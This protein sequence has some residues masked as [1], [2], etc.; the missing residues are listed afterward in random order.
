MLLLVFAASSSFAQYY[1][2]NDQYYDRDL[3]F[4]FGASI[5][6]MNSITDIGGAK[7]KGGLYV[8]EFNGK[9]TQMATGFYAGAL[10]RNLA[11]V[12]IEATWGSVRGADD[13]LKGASDEQVLN[14]YKR[15]LT[16]YSDIN[17]ISIVTEFHPLSIRETEAPVTLSP[18]IMLGI[19]RFAFNPQIQMNGRYVDL[20][21]LHTEGQGMKEYKGR[22]PYRLRQTNIPFG[23]GIKYDLNSLFTIRAEVLH[24]FL[25]TD[26]LDDVSTT[27]IDRSLFEKY[28]SPMKASQANT[29]YDRKREV[30]PVDGAMR[31]DPSNKD[32]YMTVSL[33]LGVTLGRERRR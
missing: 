15:N 33:K 8:N 24:R 10:F 26:Y 23:V 5:G 16:F 17:E 7:G 6:G 12:R 11:G 22:E 18:Y 3:V 28:L 27:Y 32:S 21:P 20:Q 14:R 4:E 1:Y 29:V 19:G 31:G 9:Y 13:V 30:A 25:F 2:Y